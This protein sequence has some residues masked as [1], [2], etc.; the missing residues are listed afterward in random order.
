MKTRR[1]LAIT[2]CCFTVLFQTAQ[3]DEGYVLQDDVRAWRSVNEQAIVDDFVALLSIPNVAS[4]TVNIRRNADHLVSQ[5]E[6]RG[7]DT[8]LLESAGPPAVFA[9]RN[10]PGA[11]R[12]ILIY[13]H[14]DG[15][16]ASAADWA[17]DPWTPVMRT[18]LVEEGG[19]EVPIAAPFD[20]QWRLFGRS[21]GDDKAPVIALLSAIDALEALGQS[22]GVNLKV[23]LEGE[24]EAGSPHLKEVL[25]ENRE[26]LQADLWLFCDGPM[27]Q[28]RRMQ[29][30]YGVRGTYG[31]DVT[32]HGPARPLHSG[33]YGN[34]APNPIVELMAL[35]RSMRDEAGRILVDGYHDEVIAPSL[36]EL[37]AIE[38][39]PSVDALL[40]DQLAIA[41]PETDERVE[42]AIMRPAMNMRGIRSGDVGEN[43]RNAIQVS[44]TASVGLRLV[45]AQTPAYLRKVIEA[46]IRKQGYHIQYSPPTSEERKNHAKNCP[47]HLARPR[48]PGLS[49]IH[50]PA[51]RTGGCANPGRPARRPAHSVTHHGRQP[52]HLPDRRRNRGAGSDP[53]GRQP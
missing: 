15:Q 36:T 43:A 25:A 3:A 19:E 6:A 8:K 23:F 50:G 28:S 7:F 47:A 16:P 10:T 45:P 21:T 35:L 51:D 44:A 38:A 17:S 33:H 48:L 24:E 42:L 53:A 14:Y 26:L 40:R 12:T 34:W 5:F 37:A 1:I 2:V 9:Q 39:A 31:F 13:I 32:L 30:V 18:G 4:D 22:P 49:R 11:E 41:A 29:L 52:A 27:H 46:H 20:P